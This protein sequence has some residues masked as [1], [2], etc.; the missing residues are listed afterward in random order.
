MLRASRQVRTSWSRVA[1]VVALGAFWCVALPGCGDDGDTVV[2]SNAVATFRV[3]LSG[4]APFSKVHVIRDG[5]YVHTVEPA[6]AEVDF[7][8]TDFAPSQGKTSYYYV[9]GEQEDGELVW[10]SPMWIR[11]DL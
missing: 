2:T 1:T 8:W 10:V 4:T 3:R 6:R 5:S 7:S 11:V 9:R